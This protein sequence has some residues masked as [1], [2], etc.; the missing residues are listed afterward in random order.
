MRCE[1][2]C[3]AEMDGIGRRTTATMRL[4]RV[5]TPAYRVWQLCAQTRE[6]IILYV[7]LVAVLDGGGFWRGV[8]LVCCANDTAVQ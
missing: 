1:F 7:C 6:Q 3:P 8:V 2:P 5:H 4:L